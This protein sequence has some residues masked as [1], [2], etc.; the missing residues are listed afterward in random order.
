MGWLKEAINEIEQEQAGANEGNAGA[1]GAKALAHP[2]K[3]LLNF[4]Q[5]TDPALVAHS[6]KQEDDGSKTITFMLP[7]RSEIE[8]RKAM[9]LAEQQVKQQP[10]GNVSQ[11]PAGGSAGQEMAVAAKSNVKVR[12]S[13]TKADVIKQFPK[14][15][16]K[17]MGLDGPQ[18]YKG[19]N[20][21]LKP[22][23]C[24][25]CGGQADRKLTEI[26]ETQPDGSVVP[27]HVLRCP[28]C[29]SSFNAK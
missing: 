26:K 14:V 5:G 13:M 8:K 21:D 1:G 7:S 19:N 28:H 10:G 29:K 12:V 4:L 17:A 23:K 25:K 22:H 3:E 16:V 15:F 2:I 9:E 11:M 6:Y 18:P 24:P 27:V 20:I